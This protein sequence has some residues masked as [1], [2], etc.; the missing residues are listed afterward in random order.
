MHRRLREERH[1]AVKRYHKHLI[2]C[3]IHEAEMDLPRYRDKGLD[4]QRDLAAVAA[5]AIW[6]S[7]RKKLMSCLRRLAR[8]GNPWL[9]VLSV[10]SECFRPSN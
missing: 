1:E 2:R 4:K 5:C 7:D 9:A 10:A 6:D 3:A 8:L